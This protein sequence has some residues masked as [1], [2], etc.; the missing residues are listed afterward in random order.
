MRMR[1]GLADVMEQGSIVFGS[2]KLMVGKAAISHTIHSLRQKE[3]R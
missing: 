2:A 3:L 1:P